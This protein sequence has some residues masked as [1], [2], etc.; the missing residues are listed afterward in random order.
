MARPGMTRPA[1]FLDRD[2][3]LIENVDTYVR[4]WDEVR[5]IPG[6]L[7]AVCRLRTS[8][9]AVVVVTNQSVVGQGIIS[10]QHARDINGRIIGQI[11]AHGGRV[12]AA[13]VCMHTAAD[14]CA[15]RKPAPGML[16]RAGAELD[17]DLTNSYMIGDAASDVAAAHAAGVQ[18]ILVRTGRG[19]EQEPL[20][21][22]PEK[23][24]CPVVRDVAEALDHIFNRVEHN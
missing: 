18:P 23:A 12:D 1:I 9:Y 7:D 19:A 5:F 3:V 4:A 16:L 24:L 11:T 10:E 2:G 21:G 8:T 20:L 13:Y 15:C 22:G 14:G 6:A 17:L